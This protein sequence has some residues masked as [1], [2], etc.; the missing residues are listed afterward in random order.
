MTLHGQ[1]KTAFLDTNALLQLFSFWETCQIAGAALDSVHSW[2]DLR[3]ILIATTTPIAS[4]LEAND[5]S[6]VQTGLN[7]FRSINQAKLSYDYFSCSVCHA[8][9]HRTILEA[10]ATERL[11][12]ERLPLSLRNRRPLLVHQRALENSDYARITGQMAEFFSSLRQDYNIDIRILEDRVHG[13]LV[14][15][16]EIL[17]TAEALWSRVLIET[18]DAYVYAAAIECEADYFLT[19][20]GALR[21]IAHNLSHPA[22]DWNA[23]AQDLRDVIGKSENF[24]FP[25]NHAPT[26]PLPA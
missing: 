20:D 5:F 25:V 8:E 3:R 4:A 19:S 13:P 9:M 24:R 12:M 22:A 21:A 26:A 2:D 1:A 16:E 18:M 11:I 14:A 23:L 6:N 10:T 15:S 17:V 7:C